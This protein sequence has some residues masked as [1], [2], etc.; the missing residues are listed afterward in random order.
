MKILKPLINQFQSL[1]E[2]SN[3][4]EE[5]DLKI[6]SIESF[7]Y[8]IN[9]L[10]KYQ[11][12]NDI[13]KILSDLEKLALGAEII[14]SFEITEKNFFNFTVNLNN[15]QKYLENFKEN[16]KTEHPKKI[17]I[18]YGG[19]NI[20]KP[21]HVGHLRSL[22]IGRSLYEINQLIGN[23]VISDIHLG[24][25]GMP[26]AQIIAYCELENININSITVQKLIDIYPKSTELYKEDES[27][28]ILA[29]EINKNL[30]KNE[31]ES[32]EKWKSIRNVSVSELKETLSILYHDFD[33]WL[34][35][36]DVNNIIKPMID[37]L[38]KEN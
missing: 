2:D 27:F 9:N 5:I 6:S 37:K 25:W 11:N 36:S 19:P 4:H 18:D 20:G 14:D 22:N 35:E 32:I 38:T 1:L 29:K 30:N 10:V 15:V 16:V 24:D 8:Q 12:H 17:I 7:D 34:G 3:I 23:T 31:K 21:L 28:Q 33:L 26:V 13:R